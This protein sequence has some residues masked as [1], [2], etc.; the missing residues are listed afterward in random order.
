[1]FV[2]L[3]PFVFVDPCPAPT[4]RYT[5]LGVTLDPPPPPV[6]FAAAVILPFASTVISA[7]V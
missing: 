5:S 4:L 2:Y 6:P 3:R 1:M 7:L